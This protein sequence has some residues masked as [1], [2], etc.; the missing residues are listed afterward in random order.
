[1]RKP[2]GRGAPV[3]RSANPYDRSV[4]KPVVKPAVKPVAKPVQKS[5]AKLVA[6]PAVIPVAKPA[7]PQF[8]D[9]FAI[10]TPGFESVTEGELRSL[11]VA[12]I[13]KSA[14]G[15]SFRADDRALVAANL[16]LRTATRV[17]V[18]VAEFSAR[19][20]AELER[21]AK[22]VRWRDYLPT[23]RNVAFRVTCKKS[24]LYHSDAVAE[25]LAKSLMAAA[26]N[27]KVVR[28]G[29]GDDED[30][31]PAAQLF[32]VR[33]AHDVVTISADASGELLHRRGYRLATA[34]APIRETIAAGCLLALGYDG[35]VP[36]ID[37]MCGAGTFAIEAALIARN[38][39][40]GIGRTFAC[41]SWP[42]FDADAARQS[43]ADAK[44]AERAL[45]AAPI[46]A[47]D[48]DAGAVKA[49]LGNA[50]RAGVTAD[51]TVTECALSAIEPPSGVGMLIANPPYG[52]RVGD[53]SDLRNLYAQFGNVARTKLGGWR[54][55]LVSAERSLEAQTKLPF[56]ELVKFSNGGIKVRLVAT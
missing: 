30:E 10:V 3:R 27:A 34:K 5:A 14:G 24:R 9:C 46:L 35:S 49:T 38:I 4:V 13:E 31:S 17:L 52:A 44:A 55:A 26:P 56:A 21:R 41:E 50:A 29:G 20:F 43:R 28:A 6:V 22:P 39:A 7:A 37:P 16:Q 48:R 8:R 36:F 1:M 18:R 15:V 11:S 25:R 42:G 40:P 33:V 45:A 51:L 32:I 23:G 2:R 47:S 12:A 19:S 54:V 53:A